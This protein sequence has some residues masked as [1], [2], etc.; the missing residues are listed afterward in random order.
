M[1]PNTLSSLSKEHLPAA[2]P[3]SLYYIQFR[4]GHDF[5]KSA[6]ALTAPS[7]GCHHKQLDKTQEGAKLVI[8]CLKTMTSEEIWINRL[9]WDKAEGP[10]DT[11]YIRQKRKT[12]L[13][14][15]SPLPWRWQHV[16]AF[17]FS[18]GHTERSEQISQECCEGATTEQERSEVGRKQSRRIWFCAQG[19][20]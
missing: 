7:S 3:K 12:A 14:S 18:K 6:S 11:I 8:R 5:L 10:Y 13:I 20:Y 9:D 2:S 4:R 15:S 1:T 19:M 16:T 17:N